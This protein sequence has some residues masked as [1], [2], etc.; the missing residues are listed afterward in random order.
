M[1]ELLNS[2]DSGN[3]L[4]RRDVDLIFAKCAPIN[5]RRLN[6]DHFLD[7]LRLI[8]QHIY[9]EEDPTN[10]FTKLLVEHIYGAFDIHSIEPNAEVIKILNELGNVSSTTF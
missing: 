7:A 9:P 2:H 6:F 8:S 10:A 5:V 1:P 3:C 4:Q